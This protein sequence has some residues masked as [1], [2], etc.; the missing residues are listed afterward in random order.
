MEKP[1]FK[2]IALNLLNALEGN[3]REDLDYTM[4]ILQNAYEDGQKAT[5]TKNLYIVTDLCMWE[6]QK[7]AGTKAP[8]AIAVVDEKTGKFRYI[9]TGA[10]IQF[11]E[12]EI[13]DEMSQE[14]YNKSNE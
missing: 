6:A 7:Q 3:E 1:N 8:H 11:L 5:E 14:S 10:R 2:V 9:K 13:S 12:G 4:H